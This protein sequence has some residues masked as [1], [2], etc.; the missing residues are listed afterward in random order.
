MN[1]KDIQKYYPIHDTVV[2]FYDQD[3]DFVADCYDD[4]KDIDRW[5]FAPLDWGDGAFP[6][7]VYDGE[8]FNCWVFCYFHVCGY[9]TEDCKNYKLVTYSHDEGYEV[10]D[11]NDCDENHIILVADAANF[12]TYKE[13]AKYENMIETAAYT[14]DAE[15]YREGKIFT[16]Y[17]DLK[18]FCKELEE[19]E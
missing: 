19:I 12:G 18:N 6:F 5:E 11:P 7:V 2:G 10:I 4:V 9:Y 16:T 15:A 1:L 3:G 14:F 8:K 17:D 13:A